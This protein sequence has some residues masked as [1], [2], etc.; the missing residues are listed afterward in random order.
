M[1]MIEFTK[2]FIAF[3]TNVNFVQSVLAEIKNFGLPQILM[4]LRLS[5]IR[6]RCD[7]M[8]GPEKYP[9]SACVYWRAGNNV[10]A[11]SFGRLIMWFF[12]I[13]DPPNFKQFVDNPMEVD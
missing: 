2:L 3:H 6:K 12:L 1:E 9:F 13:S 7:W 8:G 11:S 10:D 5:Y 4:E